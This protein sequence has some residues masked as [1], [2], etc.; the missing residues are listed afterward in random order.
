MKKIDQIESVSFECNLMEEYCVREKLKNRL[1]NKQVFEITRDF[2]DP[3]LDYFPFIFYQN[4]DY[5][6][7]EIYF[8]F[9]NVEEAGEYLD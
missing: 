9:L 1:S 2:A 8:C 6:K 4:V 7:F 5:E 3:T